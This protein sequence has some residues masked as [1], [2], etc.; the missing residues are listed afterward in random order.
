VLAGGTAGRMQIVVAF[1]R[2]KVKNGADGEESN[3]GDLRDSRFSAFFAP[4]KT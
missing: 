3:I 2:I 4:R 1:L